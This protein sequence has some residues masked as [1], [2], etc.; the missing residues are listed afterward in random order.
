[1]ISG[2]RS[3]LLHC[4]VL[5]ISTSPRAM[6]LPQRI[7]ALLSEYFLVKKLYVDEHGYEITKKWR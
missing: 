3:R 2:R 4:G 1:M 7:F 5:R 6:R